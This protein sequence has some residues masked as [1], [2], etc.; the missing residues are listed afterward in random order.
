MD[1]SSGLSSQLESSTLKQKQ[2]R[3]RQTKNANSAPPIAP[4]YPALKISPLQPI[5]TKRGSLFNTKPDSHKPN[6]P[7][8]HRKTS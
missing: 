4:L 8:D 5:P 1:K 3:P 6:S 2:R 7:H